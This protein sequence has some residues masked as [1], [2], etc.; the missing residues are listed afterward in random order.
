LTNVILTASHPIKIAALCVLLPV[1]FGCVAAYLSVHPFSAFVG[2]EIVLDLFSSAT[3]IGA[4]DF[5][6]YSDIMV[7]YF[8]NNGEALA[9]F[10]PTVLIDELTAELWRSDPD[11]FA[12]VGKYYAAMAHMNVPIV[13]TAIYTVAASFIRTAV[14][15]QKAAKAVAEIVA[16]GIN[17]VEPAAREMLG[18]FTSG[19]VELPTVE[20]P[21]QGLVSKIAAALEA[22]VPKVSFI[23]KG[24][25]LVQ[26]CG[27]VVPMIPGDGLSE[28]LK[29]VR[30]QPF[31]D[32]RE[33][34]AKV[35]KVVATAQTAV[36]KTP[37][38]YDRYAHSTA[39]REATVPKPA[40]GTRKV[41]GTA[42]ILRDDELGDFEVRAI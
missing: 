8:E 7:H 25:V 2:D 6:G 41:P 24:D 36:P 30:L 20:K 16:V 11:A 4:S 29:Q 31:T 23:K 33:Y 19:H 3:K 40:L 37:T 42:F 15:K 38:L 34:L 22:G 17:D 27:V 1:F 21:A 28:A 13:N 39:P 26:G 32:Q 35:K 14:N 12:D 10:S 9:K 18:L 5:A